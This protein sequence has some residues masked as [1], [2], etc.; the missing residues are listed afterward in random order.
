MLF[1]TATG[2]LGAINPYISHNRVPAVKKQYMGNDMPSVSLVRIVSTA[3]GKNDT[4]VPNAAKYP[5]M[6][7]VVV[8]M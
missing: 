7:T 3:C 8:M 6:V 1:A 4:V 5:M 2:K